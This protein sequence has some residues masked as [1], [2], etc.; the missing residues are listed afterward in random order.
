MS[1][2]A[3]YDTPVRISDQSTGNSYNAGF[4]TGTGLSASNTVDRFRKLYWR[5]LRPELTTR[6]NTGHLAYEQGPS[7]TV[8]AT[9]FLAAGFLVQFNDA[10]D[11]RG[12][13]HGLH[14][15]GTAYSFAGSSISTGPHLIAVVQQS[16]ISDPVPSLSTTFAESV[17]GSTFLPLASINSDGRV[18]GMKAFTWDAVCMLDV[19]SAASR[20]WVGVVM[21]D[22]AVALTNY[23][24]AKIHGTLSV[25]PYG[26]D[27]LQLR[28]PY[29]HP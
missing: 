27:A 7:D 21:V 29:V 8:A 14:F 26:G 1:Q 9:V 11:D 13:R 28:N 12:F 2:I 25:R 10:D 22:S 17:H 23:H 19:P 24:P 18:G 15:S 6:W 5:M 20:Y 16:A 3:L 4:A